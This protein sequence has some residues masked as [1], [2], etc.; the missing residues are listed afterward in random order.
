[1]AVTDASIVAAQSDAV[2]LVIQLNKHTRE[3]AVQ[4]TEMLHTVG[5]H[6][7]GVVVNRIGR[8]ANYRHY[9]SGAG[10]SYKYHSPYHQRS[11]GDS[12]SAASLGNGKSASIRQAK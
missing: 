11:N 3:R 5:A 9:R 10:Y 2:L 8:G 12:A 6:V 1:L 4:A 7:V